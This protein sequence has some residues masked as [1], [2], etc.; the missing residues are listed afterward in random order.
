ML[1]PI[2]FQNAEK[3]IAKIEAGLQRQTGW[4]SARDAELP[5]LAEEAARLRLQLAEARSVWAVAPQRRNTRVLAAIFGLCALAGTVLG[6]SG[7]ALS[8]TGVA[9]GFTMRGSIEANRH[10]KPLYDAM[11]ALERRVFVMVEVVQ[12]DPT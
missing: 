10:L 2:V 9:V 12:P 1:D 8:F 4:N 3:R 5:A 11:D 7:P 6:L